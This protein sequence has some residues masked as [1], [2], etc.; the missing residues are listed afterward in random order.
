MS[1][2]QIGRVAGVAPQN[3][4]PRIGMSPG[5]TQCLLDEPRRPAPSLIFFASN[6][7]TSYD[8]GTS[9]LFCARLALPSSP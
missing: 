3:R 7:E 2:R 4:S 1:E 9:L 6:M 8:L 5:A